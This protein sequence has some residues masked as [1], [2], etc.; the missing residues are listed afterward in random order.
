MKS[1]VVLAAFAAVGGSLH[2]Q[3]MDRRANLRGGARNGEGKCTVEVVVDGAAQVELRGDMGTLRNLNGQPPQ[4]RRFECDSPI[5]QNPVNFRFQGVDGR[6]RQTL[7]RDPRNG[8]VAVIQIEDPNNGAEGYTFDVTW[9]AGGD[10]RDGGGYIDGRPN[11]QYPTGGNYGNNGNGRGFGRPNDRRFTADQ[12][13]QIC[14]DSI[15]EQAMTQYRTRDVTFRRTA[16]DD[17]PGR[18][19]WV[20]G[21]IEIRRPN[22]PPQ[23]SRFSCSVNFDTGRVRSAQLDPG[24]MG[25]GRDFN[26]GGYG[27]G[28]MPSAAMQNCER[29]VRAR[30][31]DEGYGQVQIGP[32][33]ADDQPGR[34]DWVV[35]DMRASGRNG[36][37]SFRFSCS[38]DMRDGDVR[39]VDVMPR[40]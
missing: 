12:A 13:V 40:R 35:G 2:A 30:M 20:I 31:R 28:N 27:G 26:N 1:F 15:R 11:G 3:T 8:G 32:M 9:G 22:G 5:P 37:D 6:G 24:N 21:S 7:I 23:V 25:D 16:M 14:Q 17:A 39:S 4:W 36:S 33:R 29:A 19:D 38:V 18:N 34:R 10:P